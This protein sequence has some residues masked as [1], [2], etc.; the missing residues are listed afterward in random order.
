M[1]QAGYSVR[2]QRLVVRG[3][4]APV[5]VGSMYGTASAACYG[6]ANSQWAVVRV[7]LYARK[8]CCVQYSRRVVAQYARCSAL[9][10]G[11]TASRVASA[12]LFTVHVL[13]H[14]RML[15]RWSVEM[16]RL[17]VISRQA[18]PCMRVCQ[19]AK[20]RVST[21]QE[22]GGSSEKTIASAPVR[23]AVPFRGVRPGS[24]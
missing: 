3:V 8:V 12:L 7:Q 11:K 13:Q 2:V 15:E 22:W 21:R 10:C 5:A 14:T 9:L 23:R 20:A 6:A 17:I 19:G 4:A 16:N 24:T 1:Q 18:H